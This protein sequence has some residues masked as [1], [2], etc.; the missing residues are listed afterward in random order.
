MRVEEFMNSEVYEYLISE[1][2]DIGLDYED[3]EVFIKD[4]T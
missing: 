3:L 1:D 2:N 4:K